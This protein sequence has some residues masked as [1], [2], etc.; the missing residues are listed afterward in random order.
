MFDGVMLDGD[1]RDGTD[2]LRHLGVCLAAL[3]ALA[4]GWSVAALPSTLPRALGEQAPLRGAPQLSHSATS[5]PAT[6]H[7]ATSHPAT[8][9][10]ATSHP[11]TSRPATAAPPAQQRQDAQAVADYV[12]QFLK[13]HTTHGAALQI[14][15]QPPRTTL[16]ACDAL[17]GVM[18][19]TLR[20]RTAVAVRCLAPQAWNLT[21]QANLALPGVYYTAARTI[22]PGETLSM[23]DVRDV[24]ADLL[25][26]P[27]DT[28][29]DPAQVAGRIATQRIRKGGTIQSGSLRAPDSI[30]R[31][32]R[33]H[34]EAR[35]S[36][37]VLRGSGQALQGGAPGSMIQVRT[38]SGQVVSGLVID[39]ATVRVVM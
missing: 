9:H 8:S 29:T 36:G 20:S 33:V 15:V 34:T 6:S 28:I 27:A 17:Q 38:S 2:G 4:V 14:H 35:G 21:V 23:D 18:P 13:T 12:A 37:F 32:Q 19:N 31:G 26:L 39:A 10:P 5:H 11:A 16:P 1:M 7:S 22:A 24:Q 25:R 3:V 30:E